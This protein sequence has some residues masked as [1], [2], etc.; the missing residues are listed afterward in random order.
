MYDQDLVEYC[1]IRI[2]CNLNTSFN[3]LISSPGKHHSNLSSPV[4][5][6]WYDFKLII[7]VHRGE[8]VTYGAIIIVACK[9]SSNVTGT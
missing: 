3:F 8:T 1:Y 9:C 2:L 6:H 5:T 7:W 4:F